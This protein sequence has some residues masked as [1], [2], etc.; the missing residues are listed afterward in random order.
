MP[1]ALPIDI[2]FRRRIVTSHHNEE[3]VHYDAFTI[4]RNDFSVCRNEALHHYGS[5]LFRCSMSRMCRKDERDSRNRSRRCDIPSSERAMRKREVLA[6]NCRCNEPFSRERKEDAQEGRGSG[7]VAGVG[8]PVTF[9]GGSQEGP[10][11]VVMNARPTATKW[12]VFE[13]R[14]SSPMS[15]MLSI[16][17]SGA[18]RQPR[19]RS[20]RLRA[21]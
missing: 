3:R 11:S 18:A 19:N 21:P 4:H 10:G 6:G 7:N 20:H 9:C 1:G 17:P 15:W 13:P 5:S 16:E 14:R 8:L 2:S 12:G